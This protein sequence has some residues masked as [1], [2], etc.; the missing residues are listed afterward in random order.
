MVYE[1]K[2]RTINNLNMKLNRNLTIKIHFVLDHIIPPIVRDSKFFMY[3]LLWMMYGKNMDIFLDFKEKVP[4][5][6]G[7]DFAEIYS[8][9]SKYDIDRET[10]LNDKCVEKVTKKIEGDT[11]L[12]VGCGKAYLS[13][14]IQNLGYDVTAVDVKISDKIRSR[15]P[16]IKF[17]DQSIERL[18]FEDREFDTVVCTHT[19]EHVENLQQSIKELRRVTK[20]RLI[21]VVPRQR[22]YKYTF[23]LHIHFFPYI[24]SFLQVMK[25][26]DDTYYCKIVGGDI[27]YFENLSN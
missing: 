11:V 5:M 17:L 1:N 13:N 18:S 26:K 7:N 3:P 24:F 23:D 4:F 12:E 6:T 10:D 19:L 8:N 21:I 27:F 20:K 9:F 14:K 16:K 2:I 25:P 15:Y 22:P